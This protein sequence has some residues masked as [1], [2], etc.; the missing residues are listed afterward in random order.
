[1]TDNGVGMTA[2]KIREVL[3]AKAQVRIGVANVR[4]RIEL[5]FGA[6]YG[7]AMESCPGHWTTVRLLLPAIDSDPS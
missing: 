1:M 4:E 2:E 6:P 5:S 3:A 7:L